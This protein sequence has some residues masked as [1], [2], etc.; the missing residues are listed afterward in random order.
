MC[1]YPIAQEN[2]RLSEA[3]SALQEE[4]A[5]M[6]SAWA[7]RDVKQRMTDMEIKELG[8][9]VRCVC[10]CVRVCVCG[11]MSAILYSVVLRCLH[12]CSSM[13]VCAC[14][15]VRFLNFQAQQPAG[16]CV[17]VCYMLHAGD[18]GSFVHSVG[19]STYR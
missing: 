12:E 7:E 13:C 18:P 1:V 6:H 19:H 14:V 15:C 9:Q 2:V 4:L 5:T 8:H 10:V 17:C 16:A 11:T 3:H